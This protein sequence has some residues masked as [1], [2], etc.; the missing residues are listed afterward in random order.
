MKLPRIAIE[1]LV[2]GDSGERRYTQDSPVLPD[3]WI[4]FGLEPGKPQ[5]LLLTPHRDAS[6]GMVAVALQR[7]LDAEAVETS[8]SQSKD[9]GK[10]ARPLHHSIAYTQSSVAV[11]LNLGELVRVVLPM[12]EWWK[13]LLQTG[14]DGAA[15]NDRWLDKAIEADNLEK[16]FEKALAEVEAPT[17]PTRGR[18]APS[19]RR[20]SKHPAR[21]PRDVVWM[22]RIIG[23]LAWAEHHT[24]PA[25]PLDDEQRFVGRRQEAD[26]VPSPK[27]LVAALATLLRHGRG[28][29]TAAELL[30][31]PLGKP[32]ARVFLVN[33]NRPAEL[34]VRESRLAIKADAAWNLFKISCSSLAWAVI[35]S[36]IDA[37]HPAFRRLDPETKK[38][39][40]VAFP[41]EGGS[42]RNRTRI[43]R[44][45]DFSRVRL[46]LNPALLDPLLESSGKP[47]AKA[48]PPTVVAT[49]DGLVGD[50][51]MWPSSRIREHQREWLVGRA[52]DLHE[53]IAGGGSLERRLRD[54]LDDLRKRLLAGRDIDWQSL[55]PFLEVRPDQYRSPTNDHG[56]HVAGILAGDWRDE[57]DGLEYQGVC[58]DLELYDLRVLPTGLPGPE[59]EFNVIAALQFLRHLN[60]QKDRVMIHGA[61]LSLSIP[62]EVANFAC[63]RT[64]ICD[65]AARVVASGVVVVA[66]A[67][68]NGYL[69]YQTA[70]GERDGYHTISI[71]DPGNAEDVI[72]VGATH[73]NRPHTYGV[74]Y[75]S[76]RGPTGD[77]RRK[78][79]LVAPGEKI[80]S[81]VLEEQ[82][83]EKDGTSMAAPHASGA[84]AMLLARHRELIGQPARVKEILC[85]SATD[86]GREHYFQ[87]HGMLDVLRALQAV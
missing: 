85:S 14:R 61:N 47:A 37:T 7:G 20:R 29:V 65:E 25:E 17:V 8:K 84:A 70:Q 51:E 74:S 54:Q 24:E 72:T 35:D 26:E 9:R 64:P 86:L 27:D 34:A 40:R 82:M 59:D 16:V 19:G 55:E 33:R 53:L 52:K 79:D 21:V 75:F 3:V 60:R 32:E 18:P 66:A 56:T 49:I 67:G 50:V 5:Q 28:E 69:R 23:W 83:S 36:G 87:G 22:A 57:D 77:G 63:G 71:T 78:P 80:T 44:T 42:V 81:S 48:L 76:S 6:P 39:Y 4:A 13:R 11:R 38:P 43:A 46:L 58:P 73:R 68:N 15:Q 10:A 45:Y 30:P 12:T 31:P 2:F 41:K 62:H 1:R